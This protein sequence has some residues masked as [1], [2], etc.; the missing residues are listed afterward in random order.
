MAVVTSA[1][2]VEQCLLRWEK[3]PSIGMAELHREM[4]KR[5]YLR[6][7][8]TLA[9]LLKQVRPDAVSPDNSEMLGRLLAA[10]VA[11]TEADAAADA[12]AKLQSD[13]IRH[14]IADGISV[15]AIAAATGLTTPRLYQIRDRKR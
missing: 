4:V 1:N 2:V 15:Y 9:R 12:A 11:R 10:T 3:N 8:E 7:Y 5:G 6:S 14:A 13:L